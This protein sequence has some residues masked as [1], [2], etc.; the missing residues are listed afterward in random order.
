MRCFG[1][2]ASPLQS[3]SFEFASTAVCLG[4]GVNCISL[5]GT[6]CT[7]GAS[8]LPCAQRMKQ[9]PLLAQ[10]NHHLLQEFGFDSVGGLG[11]S[12]LAALCGKGFCCKLW[13][14]D[15][16]PRTIPKGLQGQK[17]CSPNELLV[18]ALSAL[19][20]SLSATFSLSVVL[21][22]LALVL[23]PFIS[24]FLSCLLSLSLSLFRSLLLYLWAATASRV[25][26]GTAPVLFQKSQRKL[27]SGRRWP[28]PL[29]ARS[30]L[31]KPNT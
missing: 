21:P 17:A 12:Q 7:S 25:E 15:S 4:L 20:T 10:S 23:L 24:L 13:G 29:S 11:R 27:P 1:R 18:H 19:E 31:A 9:E 2:F 26:A 30:S 22:C 6:G 3:P 14:V 5:G 16:Y 28:L 8:A